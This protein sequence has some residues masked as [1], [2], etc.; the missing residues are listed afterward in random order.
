MRKINF[1]YSKEILLFG[2]PLIPHILGGY[3][4]NAA[5]RVV[6]GNQLGLD[7]AGLYAVAFQLAASAG[8]IFDAIN[9]AYQPWLFESLNKGS[10]KVNLRIV[11]YTYAWFLFLFLGFYV[12]SFV[13]EEAL[14]FIAGDKY[15]ESA[16]IFLILLFA[17]VFKGM[18]FGV[19]NYCFY[20]KR[21]G[22][23]SAISLLSGVAQLLLLV[24]LVDI[25]GLSGAAYSYL[26]SMIFRFFATWWVSNK[27][28][29]MP[30]LLCKN[31]DYD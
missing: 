31:R 15:K 18:Y 28:Y 13:A 17:Q 27:T 3:F 14:V 1:V 6:I 5:D 22:Y 23:L 10:T 20:A 25:Y 12:F 7:S 30:W 24:W 11:R 29:H 16:N 8:L 4:L 2:V 21:T 26:L 19:V 9:K